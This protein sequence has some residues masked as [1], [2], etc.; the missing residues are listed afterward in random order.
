MVPE[1]LAPWQTPVARLGFKT[2]IPT[3]YSVLKRD[4]AIRAS[5]QRRYPRSRDGAA[6]R[7]WTLAVLPHPSQVA[8]PFLG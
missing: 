6:V 8:E 3:A 7:K 1:P 4:K 5:L 2:R